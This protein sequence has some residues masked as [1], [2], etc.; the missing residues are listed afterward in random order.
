MDEI[1]LF[2]EPELI[3]PYMIAAWPG[4]GGVSSIASRYLIDNLKAEELGILSPEEFFELSGVYIQDSIVNDFQFPENKFYFARGN[5]VR[6]WIIFAGEAQPV[7]NGYLM[8][9]II[10]DVAEKFGVKRVHTFAAAPSH[11]YHTKK[12]K[13]SAAV[14]DP[15][16]LSELGLCNISTLKEGSIS[17]M[18]GLLLGAAKHRNIEGLCLLG[19]I[20][21]YTTHIANPR[22]SKAVLQAITQITGLEIDLSDMDTWVKESDDQIEEKIV[23]LKESFGE[24]ASGLIDYFQRLAEQTTPE[25]QQPEYSEE[26]LQDIERFLKDQGDQKDE[27]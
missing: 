8:A 1:T 17:G 18:N 5:G 26:L 13:V 25:E 6:D 12:P 2:K 21:I 15:E 10:L 11:I 20:P 7:V 16:L 9:N 19:E 23:Q 27:H 24:E 4:M 14:T 22:S 3:A